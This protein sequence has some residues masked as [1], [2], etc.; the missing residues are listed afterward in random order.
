MPHIRQDANPA[1]LRALG[2]AVRKARVEAKMTQEDLATE[3][4]VARGT[5][6]NIERGSQ[7]TTYAVLWALAMAC[8]ITLADLVDDAEKLWR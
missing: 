6:A 2:R 3:I 8:G 4:E 5:I 1:A 7:N